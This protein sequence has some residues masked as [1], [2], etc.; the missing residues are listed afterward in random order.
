MTLYNKPGVSDHGKVW[1][2]LRHVQELI[3]LIRVNA[4]KTWG[5]RYNCVGVMFV[6]PNTLAPRRQK[7]SRLGKVGDP[8]SGSKERGRPEVSTL[9]KAMWFESGEGPRLEGHG[10]CFSAIARHGSCQVMC[11]LG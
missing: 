1:G 4:P 9:R 7:A 10:G 8:G 5:E 11:G 3:L 2:Q 6:T